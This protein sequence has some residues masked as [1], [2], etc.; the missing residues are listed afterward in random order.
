M[1]TWKIKRFCTGKKRYSG[2]AGV[3]IILCT[4]S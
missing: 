3:L 2:K 4:L 1:D